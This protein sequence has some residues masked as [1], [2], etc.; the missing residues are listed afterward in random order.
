LVNG[1]D[2]V[3]HEAEAIVACDPWAWSC[4]PRTPRGVQI[5]S[6]AFRVTA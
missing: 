1:L 5:A 6:L 4:I 2:G 3:I